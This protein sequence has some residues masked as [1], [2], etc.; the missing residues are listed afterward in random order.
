VADLISV[1][2]TTYEW[3]EA[4]AA[5]LRSLSRQTDR[6]FEVVVADDGSRPETGQLIGAWARRMPVPLKHV[7]HEDRGF[8]AAEI[9]NRAVRASEG[10]IFVFLDG[11]CLAR[12]DFV[13]MHRRLAEPRWF[14]AGNRILLSR[15]LTGRVLSEGLEPE[16]WSLRM[17][18]RQRLAGGVNRALPALRAPFGWWR[19]LKKTSW[20]GVRSCNL[21]IRREDFEQ[22]DGFDA[23][24]SG[25]GLEDSDLVV[26]LLH[27][28]IRRKDGRF[29]TGVFHLW[30]RELDRSRFAENQ[31]QLDELLTGGRVR[32]REGLSWLIAKEGLGS[33]AAEPVPHA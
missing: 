25:W 22:V 21:A 1:I 10:A 3:P 23:A 31:R 11:D 4:L 5:V 7:W 27:A 6:G 26:R 16:T 30:H 18:L 9:R 15:E 12:P 28:G 14:V 29:A 19:C 20:T 2:V 17:L 24:F 8:R 33:A 32:A 13:A